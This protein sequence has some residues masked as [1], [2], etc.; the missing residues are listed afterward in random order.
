MYNDIFLLVQVVEVVSSYPCG[1]ELLMGLR[2]ETRDA[3]EA[4]ASPLAGVVT[5]EDFVCVRLF[6]LLNFVS[7]HHYFY[8]TI[9]I[10]LRWDRV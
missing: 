2:A 9:E 3:W 8:Q 5:G 1:N 10:T 6:S 4:V 7:R